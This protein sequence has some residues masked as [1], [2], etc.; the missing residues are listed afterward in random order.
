MC[1]GEVAKV[2]RKAGDGAE[3]ITPELHDSKSSI[4]L[5]TTKVYDTPKLGLAYKFQKWQWSWGF[6]SSGTALALA[7]TKPR[8]RSPEPK[9]NNKIK[10]KRNSSRVEG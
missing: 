4:Y 6:S 1:L 7:S 2:T 3:S 10:R 8:V 5:I 9:N